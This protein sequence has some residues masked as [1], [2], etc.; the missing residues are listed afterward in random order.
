VPSPDVLR[1]HGRSDKADY[2]Y[3]RLRHQRVDYF[4]IALNDIICAGP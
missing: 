4:A 2:T 3:L 1:Y